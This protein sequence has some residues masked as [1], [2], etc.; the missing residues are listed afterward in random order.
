M[1]FWTIVKV[2]F[3]SIAANKMRSFLTMLGVIIGVG[4]VIA[5]LGLGAGTREKVM[6]SVKSMG[7]NLL[8]IRA[9]Q[10][11]SA[12]VMSGT[13]QNLKL[14][15][16]EAVLTQVPEVAL[17]CPEVSGRYQ[18]KYMNKNAQ[19]NVTGSAITYFKARN[20]QIEK[21]HSFTEGD[22]NRQARLAVIGAKTAT[23]LFGD[24]EPVGE[25]IK[26]KGINFM[27][28][29]VTKS[30]G[31]QGWFNPDEMLVI[32]YTTAMSQVMG[33][34][35]LG[36]IYAQV[37]DGEDMIKTQEKISA[38]MRRQHKTQASAPDDFTIRNL[39]EITDSLNQVSSIFTML[40]AGVAAVSLLV[41]G[42]GIMNI[43][44]VTVTERTREIGVRKAIGARK[45]DLMS[46]FLLEA[47]TI[48]LTGGL[49]GVLFGVSAI[50]V[51]NYITAEV[52]GAAF[53]AKIQAGPILLS[54][55]FSVL[56]GVFFGWYPARKASRL[57]PIEALRYE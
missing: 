3:K 55:F 45:I 25:T 8:V 14:E 33:R 21:G 24:Q 7:A 5:M 52:S 9:G 11:A 50:V 26:I 42:I 41:G 34:D 16:A 4:A 30:K 23:D 40:L 32:P 13:Q 56:V 49:I 12:G 22:V 54:F 35:F 19:T 37:R 36:S 57:D 51:F 29:G 15:D 27:V 53:G 6:E 38:V 43:M 28:V 39:Q 17:V 20:F 18:A 44:L 31:D 46:Q 1:L 2:A 10:R 47:V 48:S